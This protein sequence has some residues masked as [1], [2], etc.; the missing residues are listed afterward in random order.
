MLLLKQEEQEI[1][2]FIGQR[3][4]KCWLNRDQLTT[5][6]HNTTLS[7]LTHNRIANASVGLTWIIRIRTATTDW[8][9][10]RIAAQKKR[11]FN[12]NLELCQTNSR[13][14]STLIY[15]AGGGIAGAEIT[16]ARVVRRT[17]SAILSSSI[18]INAGKED[19]FSLIRANTEALTEEQCR[20]LKSR[21]VRCRKWQKQRKR[22]LKVYFQAT[23]IHYNDSSDVQS[24]Q[25]TY[26]FHNWWKRCTQSLAANQ[27]RSTEYNNNKEVT[28]KVVKK[29]ITNRSTYRKYAEGGS[30]VIKEGD[31]KDEYDGVNLIESLSGHW[32][33]CNFNTRC[34]CTRGRHRSHCVCTWHRKHQCKC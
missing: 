7:G 4:T 20:N 34:G 27:C 33:P 6:P 25:T 12:Q 26:Q 24:L 1:N 23:T 13:D 28:N 3:H 22:N 29:L 15:A 17:G 8:V 30:G 11:W 5:V 32:T 21:K 2:R 10:A 16:H 31:I 9:S 14:G 19:P 18:R